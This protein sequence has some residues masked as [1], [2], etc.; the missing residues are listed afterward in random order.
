MAAKEHV[1]EDLKAQNQRMWVE[2]MNY[3]M[4]RAMEMVCSD[5]IYK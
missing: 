1:D 3:I 5:L 2:D 4:D